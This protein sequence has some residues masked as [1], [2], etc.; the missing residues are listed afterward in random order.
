M[1]LFF[2]KKDFIEAIVSKEFE[3]VVRSAIR[4]V[5]EEYEEASERENNGS[6][7]KLITIDL[8]PKKPTEDMV[9]KFDICPS[10]SS[11]QH[12]VSERTCKACGTT[13]KLKT[14]SRSIRGVR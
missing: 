3:V 5:F 7:A 1:S 14:R 10:C 6:N 2:K 11:K 4:D 12:R 13:T 9:V 8:P